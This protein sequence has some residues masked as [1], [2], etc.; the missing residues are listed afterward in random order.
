MRYTAIC[1]LPK[2]T[3]P[4]QQSCSLP[5]PVSWADLLSSS[6]KCPQHV[7]R[8]TFAPVR[9]PDCRQSTAKHTRVRG[10]LPIM[11]SSSVAVNA[12]GTRLGFHPPSRCHAFSSMLM[13]RLPSCVCVC[14]CV[15]AR[16]PSVQCRSEAR[17]ESTCAVERSGNESLGQSRQSSASPGPNNNSR[18]ASVVRSPSSQ[19]RFFM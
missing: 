8:S 1:T 6:L 12:G 15:F 14:V 2:Q 17:I 10:C 16:T 5:T 18:P 13:M 9:K 3:P 7:L 11:S 19:F 4:L